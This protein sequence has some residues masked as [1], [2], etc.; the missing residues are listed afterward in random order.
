MDRTDYLKGITEGTVIKINESESDN[1]EA[2]WIA[3]EIVKLLGGV[4]SLSI[5]SGISDGE[6]KHYGFSDF[7]VLCRASF[8]FD[9]IIKAFDSQGIPYQMIDNDPFYMKEPYKSPFKAI[10]E[11]YLSLKRG[12]EIR[13]NHLFDMIKAGESF[14]NVVLY[15]FKNQSEEYDEDKVK[16]FTQG[17]KDYDEFIRL[18]NLRSGVDDYKP[19]FEAV[20]IIT[21]HSAKGLE[22][23]TVFIP[24][25][26][27]MI[28][29]FS[30]FG[31]DDK[32]EDSP[33]ENYFDEERRIFYVALTRS[34]ERLYL[35]HATKRLFRGRILTLK[36]SRFLEKISHELVK[37]EKREQKSK[38]K[39]DNQLT[40]F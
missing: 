33:E 34:K 6:N 40:M 8:M 12:D 5:D 21:I 2:D 36:K 28:I 22:F 24:G 16:R 14:S 30:I 10:R 18:Y 27:E 13:N 9:P 25:C 37:I 29:P 11:C 7:A 35:S 17:I 38:K 32:A 3:R 20:P 1:S 26:E 23:K 15:L 4:R 31:K 39:D 19:E